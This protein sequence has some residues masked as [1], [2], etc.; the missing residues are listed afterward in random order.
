MKDR[1]PTFLERQSFYSELRFDHSSVYTHYLKGNDHSESILFKKKKKWRFNK[2]VTRR[3]FNG[4]SVIVKNTH[5]VIKKL[6]CLN[7]RYNVFSYI[8]AIYSNKYG[9]R[10]NSKIYKCWSYPNL[11]LQ[12]HRDLVYIPDHNSMLYHMFPTHD[13]N[14]HNDHDIPGK[15]NHCSKNPCE[16]FSRLQ[17][18]WSF[19]SPDTRPSI[20]QPDPTCTARRHRHSISGQMSYF[21]LLGYNVNKK[22]TGS[23]NSLFSTAVISGSS[24]A[25]NLKD[26]V[27]PHASAVAGES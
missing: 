17:P 26:M 7:L 5:I 2:N 25:P 22:L 19:S 16:P 6:F 1:F 24:S 20:I 11:N 9:E 23:A 8:D 13:N 14:V 15:Y 3:T 4:G 10:L 18:Q 21:K 27:P 12:W